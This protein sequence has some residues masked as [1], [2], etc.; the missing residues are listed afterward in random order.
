MCVYVCMCVC[1]YV[2]VCMCM[3]NVMCM[4]VCVCVCCVCT[5][6]TTCM[7]LCSRAVYLMMVL[8]LLV[9]AAKTVTRNQVSLVMHTSMHPSIP[10]SSS[11]HDIIQKTLHAIYG[12]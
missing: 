3:C 5:V 12:M 10:S 6:Y 9:M 7:Q 11:S 2:F 4:C 1:V 8:L